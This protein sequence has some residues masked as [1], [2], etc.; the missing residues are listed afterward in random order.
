MQFNVVLTNHRP[1]S[2]QVLD[3]VLRPLLFGL[4]AAGHRV[5]A[6]AR[7][8]EKAPVVNL[9]VE[10]F[11]DPAFAAL[12]QDARKDWAGDLVLGAIC[13]LGIDASEMNEVRRAALRAVL[14]VVDFAW[15]L[16]P[17]VLPAGLMAADRVVILGY[18]FNDGLVGPRLTADPAARDIDVVLYSPDHDR[19]NDLVQ[20]LGAAKLGHFVLRP[21]VLPD[22][23]AT[24]IL[25]RGKVAV[26]IGD[27]R[28]A[29][30]GLLPR[31]LKAV[32]NGVLVVTEPGSADAALGEMAVD[33]P[34][35]EIAAQC[36][37]IVDSGHYAG[38]G[39]G[40]FERLKA[41]SM[42][43]ALGPALA[44]PVLARAR[45]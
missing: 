35:E 27:R 22:Y 36:R 2:L 34:Y 45:G 40:A 31:I 38:R 30:R 10:D 13:P 39:L 21:G 28:S 15:T 9:V 42:A 7:R 16:A 43:E 24:D 41:R 25:S 11:S 37:A 26:V 29:A 5:T 14:P 12:L 6:P 8:L 32:C 1:A 23:L 18:G 44:L 4:R 19:L 3:D 33:C 17:N 20:R